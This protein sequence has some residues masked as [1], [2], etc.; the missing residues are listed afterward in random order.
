[1][2]IASDSAGNQYSGEAVKRVR[3]NVKEHRRQ[4]QR[5]QTNSAK[6]RLRKVSSR[7]SR[8]VRDIKCIECG[9]EANADFVG[10]RNIQARAELSD[11]LLFSAAATG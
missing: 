6:K 2:Q 10:S 7:Q 1:V 3:K 4:L 11:R 9:L 5:K 8:F